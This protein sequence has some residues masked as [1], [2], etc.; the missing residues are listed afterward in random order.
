MAKATSPVRRRPDRP[1]RA[2]VDPAGAVRAGR[3]GDAPAGGHQARLLQRPRPAVPPARGATTTCARCASSATSAGSRTGRSSRPRRPSATSGSSPASAAG[4]SGRSPASRTTRGSIDATWFG[5][6]FIER[7]LRVGSEIVVSGQGQALRAAADPR[8]PRVPGRR[9]RDGRDRAAPRRPDRAGLPADRGPDRG[10]APGG[11]PRGARQGRQ[12]LPRIPAGGDRRARSASCRSPGRSRRPTT[13]TR[14]RAGTRRCAGWPSTSSWRSSSGW[15]SGGGSA[16][17]TRRP[18]IRARRARPTARSARAIV[19]AIGARRRAV[20]LTVDQVVAMTPSATTSPGRPRCCGCSRATSGSGKTAVA[21][22]AL[23]A[24][25]RAG[26]QGALLAPTD[27]LARQH[28]ETVGALLEDLGHRR[29]AAD[30]L[31]QGRCQGQ[32]ARGDRV[33][34]GARRR[35]H[36]RAHPGRGVVRR[37]RPRRHRRAA[38]FRRRP[39]RRARGEGRRPLAARPADDRDAHPA[40]ARPGPVRRPRRLGPADAA[41]RARPDPDRRQAPGRPR[42]HV[43]RRSARRPRSATGRSS[44]CR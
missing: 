35:R 12:R 32:G 29:H 25:A 8:Q 5:R 10:P 36:P 33:G 26:L 27:L 30:R 39:A 6:R 38:P 41:G 14:S 7:R 24:T 15:S 22:Y 31:A 40:D 28:L 23:A 42:R 17:A 21:A 9:R 37:P 4:P 34:P 13:R 43:A 20:E 2:A 11:H 44:S 19:D 3:R 16:S 1:G 18:E